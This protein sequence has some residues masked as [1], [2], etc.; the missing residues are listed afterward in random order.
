MS[1]LINIFL[2]PGKVFAELKEKPTFVLPALLS[3]VA[4]AASIFVYFMFVDPEWFASH[5]LQALGSEM[6]KAELEQVSKM[7]PGARTSGYIGAVSVA[8]VTPI[9]YCIFSLYYLL[10]GKIT[11]NVISFKQGLSLTAWA[12]LPMILASVLLVVGVFTSS[13]QTSLESLQLLN[14]DPLLVQLPMDHDWSRLAKSFS[15]LNF[16]VWFLS[17]LGWKTWFRTGWGQALGVV[18]LPSLLIYG[19]MAL[20]ALI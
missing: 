7:M 14:I 13:A 10:A 6:S 3:I 5:Q 4:A 17:A 11:G 18:M 9:I 16:W 1:H 20:M 15:L 19:V 12:S 8:I 2:E